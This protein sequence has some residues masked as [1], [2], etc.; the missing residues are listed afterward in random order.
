MAVYN[1]GDAL[2]ASLESI[3]TQTF[4]DW[5]MVVVDDASTDRTREVVESWGRKDPR[6]RLVTNA[7]NKGQTPCLNQGLRECRGDWVARQDADDL[8]AP[9]RLAAQ[10]DFVVRHP[11]VALLG[12][13]GILIDE[14]GCKAG[15]L[16]VPSTAAGIAWTSMFLNPFL[17]TSVLFQRE[18]SLET[19]GGYDESFRIAQDYDLWVR[20]L[21]AAPTA[22]LPERLVSYRRSDASLSR[23]GRELAMQEAGRVASR[24][25]SHLIG[26]SPEAGERRLCDAFRS[27]LPGAACP[28][29]RSLWRRLECEF[30]ARH[31]AWADGPAAVAA[32]WHLRLAG[33]SGS[34]LS[35]V[36]EMRDALVADPGFV[37]RWIRDRLG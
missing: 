3:A 17:H 19:F 27:G 32:S 33:S 21:N 31:P 8:S 13:S 22:N 23:A 30:S 5:E 25:F 20:M 10:M 34:A 15:L 6:I 36:S 12:T 26:R 9:G 1:G 37:L 14:R 28:E 18:T 24:Q 4:T 29:F 7:G 35:A 16:D 11:E 2:S